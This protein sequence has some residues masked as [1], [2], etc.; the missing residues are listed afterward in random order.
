MISFKRG[1]ATLLLPKSFYSRESLAAGAL[2]AGD[3]AL[4]YLEEGSKAYK[5]EFKWTKGRAG[6]GG[7]SQRRRVQAVGEFLNE[8]LSHAYRQ[9]VVAFNFKQTQEVFSRL[10]ARGF[11]AVAA[12]PLEELEPQVRLDR[13]AEVGSLM[14]EAHKL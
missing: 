13:E 7:L 4:V 11:V 2:A 1:G 5:I 3:R 14:E 9:K 10:L 12:D 6:I 8:A